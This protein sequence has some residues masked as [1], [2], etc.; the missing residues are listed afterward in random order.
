METR[1]YEVRSRLARAR[2]LLALDGANARAEIESD[3]DCAT[4]LVRSTGAISYEPQ[5]VVERARLAKI[6]GDSVRSVA[7]KTEA[8]RLFTAIGA[9]GHAE[10]L[11]R[12]LK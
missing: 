1:V 4:D 6:L 3:L 8:H 7:L 11:A 5:I 9:T 12:E 2:I 10:R